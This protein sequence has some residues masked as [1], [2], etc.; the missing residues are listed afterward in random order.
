MQTP[1]PNTHFAIC[2]VLVVKSSLEQKNIGL[3]EIWGGSG[4]Q[5]S[6]GV[7]NVLGA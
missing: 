1:D 5:A 7:L 2:C 3:L 4:Y 6:R